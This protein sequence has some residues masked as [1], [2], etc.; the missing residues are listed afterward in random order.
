MT[1]DERDARQHRRHL[2]AAR[3]VPTGCERPVSETLPDAVRRIVQHLRPEKIILFGSYAH[4]APTPDSDVDLLVVMK[5]NAP[6]KERYWAVSRLL[7]P[8]PF[9][10]DILVKTPQEIARALKK[11]D[12]VRAT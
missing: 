1:K 12:F 2:R 3:I 7:I 5:T 6:T 10:V 9:P 11:G 4:G 8:R